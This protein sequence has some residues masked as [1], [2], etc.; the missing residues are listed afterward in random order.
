MNVNNQLPE[1]QEL[2]SLLDEPIELQASIPKKSYDSYTKQM[3]QDQQVYNNYM[4]Y[5][6]AT[7]FGP[8]YNNFYNPFMYGSPMVP[9]SHIP[10]PSYR[11]P[12]TPVPLMSL[13]ITKPTKDFN[14]IKCEIVER[15]DSKVETFENEYEKFMHLAGQTKSNESKKTMDVA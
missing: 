2:N 9:Q 5:H 4:A 3:Y 13:N 1:K 7:M 10:M 15:V 6:S 12:C 14:Q 11:L 8:T